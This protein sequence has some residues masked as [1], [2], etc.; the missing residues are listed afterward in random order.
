MIIRAKADDRTPTSNPRP[1]ST[2][3]APIRDEVA[4]R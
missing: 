1:I 3:D 4:A 2:I